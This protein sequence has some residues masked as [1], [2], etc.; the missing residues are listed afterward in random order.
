MRRDLG[1]ELIQ[2]TERALAAS[3][4]Y[5]HAHPDEVWP[6]VRRHAQEMEDDVMRQHINLYVNEF[7]RDYGAEG[8]A[9]I[10]ILLETAE[11]LGAVPKSDRPIF[12]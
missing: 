2:R 9:A 5:A 7:T 11:R 1:Q 10:Q 12:E 4:D 8:Q 3:V 6:T